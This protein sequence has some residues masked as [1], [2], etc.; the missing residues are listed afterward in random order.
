MNLQIILILTIINVSQALLLTKSN[1]RSCLGEEVVFTCTTEGSSLSWRV[2][3]TRDSNIP[4]L[5]YTFF[6]RHY[7][8]QS[9]RKVWSLSGFHI[10]L[11]FVSVE[12]GPVLVSTLS[13]NMTNIITDAEVTCQQSSQ[14]QTGH[15]SLASI[16]L[17]PGIRLTLCININFDSAVICRCAI[18]SC[19]NNRYRVPVWMQKF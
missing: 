4:A 15:F 6:Y 16:I 18:S 10:E 8:M 14:A 12:P 17:A 2:I 1:S 13:A 3:V 5:A 11:Q 19:S 9:R 7:E